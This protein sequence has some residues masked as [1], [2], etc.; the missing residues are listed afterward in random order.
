V[1]R[2]PGPFSRAQ[3]AGRKRIA[4][5]ADVCAALD[6]IAPFRYAAEWD[7][8]GLLGGRPEWPVRRVLLAIDLTDMVATEALRARA[9]ALVLYHPPIFKGLRAITPGAGGPT[10]RLP[11][12]LAARCCIFAVHTALD[13]AAGGTNDVLLDVFR[14]VARWPLEPQ[15][16]R[17]PRY[18]LVVFVPAAEVDRLRQALSAA[19]AGQI[20]HYHECSFELRGRGTFRGDETTRPSIGRPLVLECVDEIRLEMVVPRER[21]SAAVRAL[22]ANHPYEEPAFDL[23]P[24]DELP[25]RGEIGM[26]RVGR[27]PRP[28]RGYALLDQLAERVD[29]AAAQV[30]GSLKRVFSTVT[31]AAG[32]FGVN[33]FRDADSLVLTGEIK[34]HEALELKCRGVTAVQLGHYASERPALGVLRARLAGRLRGVACRIARADAAPLIPVRR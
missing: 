11:D 14:P 31:A 5:A 23:Y 16:E 28:Q 25:A 7:N 24:L 2:R 1:R 9:D 8:V 13:V 29:L 3:A 12:L 33:A 4:T 27:L 26:G 20:G 17:G 6:A 34:H 18:K 21:L 10:T 19:G 22:Y 30:V 15:V 32:A